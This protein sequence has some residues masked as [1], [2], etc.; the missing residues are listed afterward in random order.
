MTKLRRVLLIVR[1]VLLTAAM[2][3]TLWVLL[4]ARRAAGEGQAPPTPCYAGPWRMQCEGCEIQGALRES[5]FADAV[6]EAIKTL[7]SD[8]QRT[9][10]RSSV[11]A[12]VNGLRGELRARGFCAASRDD[13]PQ[14][15][16]EQIAVWSLV[17]PRVEHLSVCDSGSQ[18]VCSAGPGSITIVARGFPTS[19]GAPFITNAASSWC[20]ENGA[21]DSIGVRCDCWVVRVKNQKVRYTLHPCG[22]G[23]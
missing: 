7:Y 17:E 14:V 8:G 10:L 18:D 21:L 2:L 16:A 20:T 1:G 12:Y 9:I 4:S 3:A 22:S 15:P 5:A 13:S 23:R 6:R 19:E 11:G